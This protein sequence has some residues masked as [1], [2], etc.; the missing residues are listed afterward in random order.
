MKAYQDGKTARSEIGKYIRFY[1]TERPHQSLGY[2]TPAEEYSAQTLEVVKEH[3]LQ[4]DQSRTRTTFITRI[5]GS[6]LNLE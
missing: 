3:M 5:A 6:H 1:N 2:K 4:S